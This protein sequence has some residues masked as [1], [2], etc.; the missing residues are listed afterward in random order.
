MKSKTAGISVSVVIFL[1]AMLMASPLFAEISGAK[2]V[3]PEPRQWKY[4]NPDPEKVAK[5]N[6]IKLVEKYEKD[7]H[8]KKYTVGVVLNP[9]WHED[10]AYVHNDP[11]LDSPN[12]TQ[13]AFD[14]EYT[15]RFDI[16][17]YKIPHAFGRSSIEI[18]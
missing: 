9:K 2:S 17:I 5:D 12:Y 4:G 15:A 10:A 18:A 11:T 13:W 1:F 6:K 7:P 14:C 8:V 16:R 3:L